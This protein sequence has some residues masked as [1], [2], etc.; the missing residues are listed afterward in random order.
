LLA[1]R[2]D[3]I[4]K[5]P[6][7]EQSEGGKP[8]VPQIRDRRVAESTEMKPVHPRLYKSRGKTGFFI[9]KERDDSYRIEHGSV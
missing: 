2:K 8:R 3:E 4:T 9:S 1:L 6:N 7:S 5:K